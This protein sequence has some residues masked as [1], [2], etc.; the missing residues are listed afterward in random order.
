MSLSLQAERKFFFNLHNVK[1]KLTNM[2][3]NPENSKMNLIFNMLETILKFF[4]ILEII[5]LFLQKKVII[6]IHRLLKKTCLSKKRINTKISQQRFLK[7][8]LCKVV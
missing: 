4:L 1:K 5:L 6:Q 2:S 7:F 8:I 3:Y